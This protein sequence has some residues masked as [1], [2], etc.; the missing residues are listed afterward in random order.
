MGEITELEQIDPPS[1]LQW[2]EAYY[3]EIGILNLIIIL[4]SLAA[5]LFTAL[6]TKSENK[7]KHFRRICIIGIFT[8]SWLIFDSAKDLVNCFNYSTTDGKMPVE[9][10]LTSIGE[11]AFQIQAIALHMAMIA[12]LLL[13]VH[14]KK[15]GI[16]SR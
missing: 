12:A 4:I 9:M 3:Q 11:R 14:S 2:I 6:K 10:V 15:D 7:E 16:S 1:T 13:L 5:C 8:S